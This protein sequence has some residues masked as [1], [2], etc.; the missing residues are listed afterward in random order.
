[1]GRLQTPSG[2]HPARIRPASGRQPDSCRRNVG[3]TTPP[4]RR[5]PTQPSTPLDPFPSGRT[6][7]PRSRPG[8]RPAAKPSAP[9]AG[10]GESRLRAG[11]DELFGVAELLLHE[12]ETGIPEPGIGEID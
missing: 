4:V 2:P 1:M 10:A 8:R 12:R 11:R 5:D 3:T 6:P 7:W 9:K